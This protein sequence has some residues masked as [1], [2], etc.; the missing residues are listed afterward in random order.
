[1]AAAGLALVVSVSLYAYETKL[2]QVVKY[3][4][5]ETKGLLICMLYNINCLLLSD[6]RVPA[7]LLF[8]FLILSRDEYYV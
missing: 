3:K 6:D 4:I 7:M 5:A 2:L 8:E 1:M